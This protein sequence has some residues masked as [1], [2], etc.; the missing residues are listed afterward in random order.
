MI[1]HQ[2]QCIFIHIP[3]CAGTSIEHALGHFKGH[4]GRAGQDHR[5]IRMLQAPMLE[6]HT[7]R[8]LD[9]LKDVARRLRHKFRPA[10]NPNNRL[11]VDRLQYQRY[12]KFAVV[13]NPW[14]R[15]YSWYQNAMRDPIH[16]RNYG[17]AAGMSFNLFLRQF[18]GKGFLRPQTYWLNNFAGDMC[19]DYVARFEH[20]HQDFDYIRQQ[21]QL[22]EMPL[23][24]KIEGQK[25]DP[26]LAF[27]TESIELIAQYYR[28][29]IALFGY[30]FE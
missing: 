20:L 30:Q 6:R 21:L 8:N 25:T 4:Q 5:S 27:D 28:D 23:P 9:N 15:A 24:H 2:H 10:A 19:M 11:V 7:F 18:V 17:I 26:R 16:Q 29:E 1:S 3:K 12:F 14:F 13:R 22:D